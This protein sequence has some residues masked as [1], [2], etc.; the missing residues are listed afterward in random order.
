MIQVFRTSHLAHRVQPVTGATV[1]EA[2]K[3]AEDWA[4]SKGLILENYYVQ[5]KI[6]RL[7]GILVGI[8]AIEIVPAGDLTTL[9]VDALN[10]QETLT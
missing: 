10:S 8:K 4:K 7:E 2:I 6:G 5:C 9:V 1:D 3:S